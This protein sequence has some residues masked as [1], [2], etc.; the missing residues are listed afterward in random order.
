MSYFKVF[1]KRNHGVVMT[2][3]NYKYIRFWLCFVL[4]SCLFF[5][6]T[7][8]NFDG[9]V[10]PVVSDDPITP[11]VAVQSPTAELDTA[12]PDTQTIDPTEAAT[13]V[14]TQT[15]SLTP[16]PTSTPVPTK[17]PTSV[18]TSSPT[19]TLKPTKAPTPT[20]TPTP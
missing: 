9:I 4:V 7:A 14:A 18:P 1:Y 20:P 6:L 2:K 15:P 3:V 12:S 11:P 10:D 5:I 13:P 8:C 16:T 19:P 17:A